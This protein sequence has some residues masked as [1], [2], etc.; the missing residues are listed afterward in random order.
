MA[1]PVYA[2]MVAGIES[3]IQELQAQLDEY[4]ELRE[5]AEVRLDSVRELP[6]ALIK[7]RIAG[8]YTQA[9]L[10]NRLGW[11]PQQV[12]RY[13]ATAYRSASLKRIL[14][15]LEALAADFHA[16]IHLR[17]DHDRDPGRP[18]E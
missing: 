4:D 9:E 5:A 11:K 6:P 18:S 3:Q 2:A 13:E 14:D 10:A 12:Q 17:S 8:G 16:V 7:A 15:V 1:P